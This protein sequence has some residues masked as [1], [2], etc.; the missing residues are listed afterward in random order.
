MT[1]DDVFFFVVFLMKNSEQ[2]HPSQNEQGLVEVLLIIFT[3]RNIFRCF[4]KISPTET[5][6]PEIS[7]ERP[8][9]RRPAPGGAFLTQVAVRAAIASGKPWS[10]THQQMVIVMVIEYLT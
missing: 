2:L 7:S 1:F 4:G 3:K 6:S 5:G 10:W 9:A 8:A